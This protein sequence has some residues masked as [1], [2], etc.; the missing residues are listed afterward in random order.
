MEK[1]ICLTCE[2]AGAS[3]SVIEPTTTGTCPQC[4]GTVIVSMSKFT[5]LAAD[6][7]A[8]RQQSSLKQKSTNAIALADTIEQARK[9]RIESLCE[10]YK[11][12]RRFLGRNK[13]VEQDLWWDG[14]GVEVDYSMQPNDSDSEPVEG[15][16][17]WLALT[18]KN[19]DGT[20][21]VLRFFY[22]PEDETLREVK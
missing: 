2:Q 8:K 12:I 6:A 9:R 16:T 11:P 13:F 10:A 15:E 4:N 5:E 14:F 3:N 18:L 21:R 22:D 20:K 7:V 19:S 1:H 17:E